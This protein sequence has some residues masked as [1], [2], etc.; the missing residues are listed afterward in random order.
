MSGFDFSNLGGLMQMAQQRMAELKTQAEALRCEGSAAGGKV[1][2]VISGDYQ[3]HSVEIAGDAMYDKEL[4]EDMVR[5]ATNDAL[6]SVRL[7][8]S[9]KVKAMT[10]GLP[11]P[12]GLM[13]F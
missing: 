3:V 5:A 13:P 6:Q 11:I 12:P 4:L 7:E 8:L 2:V 9:Q 10:G 1:K